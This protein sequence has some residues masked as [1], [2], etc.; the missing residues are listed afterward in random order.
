MAFHFVGA[1]RLKSFK[2]N[3]TEF[4]KKYVNSI[5]SVNNEKNLKSY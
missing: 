2:L 5:G 4:E 1:E 3:S